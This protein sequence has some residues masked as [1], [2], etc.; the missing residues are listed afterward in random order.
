MTPVEIGLFAIVLLIIMLAIRVPVGISLIFAAGIGSFMLTPGGFGAALTV[1]SGHMLRITQTQPLAV[2]PLFIL[3]GA[4]AVKAGLGEALFEVFSF[5]FRKRR[6]GAAMAAIGTNALLGALSGSTSNF[7]LVSNAA[8]VSS[9]ASNAALTPSSASASSPASASNQIILTPVIALTIYAF[10][11]NQSVGQLIMAGIIPVVLAAAA[12]IAAVPI[13]LLIR[14]KLADKRAE[15]SSF[16]IASLKVVWVV[17]FIFLVVFGSI[18][19]GW[20]TPVEAGAAGAF[21]ALLF[22]I[23]TRRINLRGF[24]EALIFSAKS[25]AAIFLL[26]IGGSLFGLLLTRSLISMEL[27]AFFAGLGV[28]AVVFVISILTAYMLIARV[29]S[30]AAVLVLFTPFVYPI[31]AGPGTRPV[32]FGVLT[33]VILLTAS[34]LPKSGNKDTGAKTESKKSAN[35]TLSGSRTAADGI[36]I[37]LFACDYPFRLTLLIVCV[38]ISILPIIAMALPGLMRGW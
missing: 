27:A 21:L 28:P 14:P 8:W 19:M 23:S 26:I 5:L 25:T 1:V 35:K 34:L 18:F 10:L 31:I 38:I 24:I 4:F 17:P 20:M 22:A 3:M 16:P 12:L 30:E 36:D 29:V 32:W 2:I 6:G 11:A 33:V 37:N 9:T 7:G 13:L 15:E